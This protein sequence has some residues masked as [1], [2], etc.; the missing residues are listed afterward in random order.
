M[1]SSCQSLIIIVIFPIVILSCDNHNS[2]FE[3]IENE[4]KKIVVAYVKTQ[5]Y[6]NKIN[7]RINKEI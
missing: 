1:T 7:N 6:K 5:I 4:R 2:T 3:G